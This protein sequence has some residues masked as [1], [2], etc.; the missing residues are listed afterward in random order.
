M[1]QCNSVVRLFSL[2]QVK[3][4]LRVYGR[5]YATSSSNT[6]DGP[7][8][9]FRKKIQDGELKEDAHQDEVVEALQTLYDKIQGYQPVEQ[10]KPNKLLKWFT[11]SPNRSNQQI[12][13][14]LYI[15][16]SV[17]GGKTTL[18]D[19]FYDSCTKVE[20]KFH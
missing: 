13:K 12:P 17:G 19:I 9:I 16:G 15:H 7:T 14:G 20:T 1:T 18:M 4:I 6:R 3:E 11:K 5:Y 10:P 8:E 2:T